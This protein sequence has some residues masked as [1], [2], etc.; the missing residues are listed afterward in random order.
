M[1]TT[2]IFQRHNDYGK[3]LSSM[4]KEELGAIDSISA[5]SSEEE[6]RKLLPGGWYCPL[7]VHNSDIEVLLW[8]RGRLFRLM[9]APENLL[10]FFY[11][12]WKGK[13]EKR[14]KWSV[15]RMLLKIQLAEAERRYEKALRKKTKSNKT[16]KKLEKI[17]GD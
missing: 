15:A 6:K 16:R 1:G 14:T 7:E 13:V 5:Y 10:D 2:T 9:D 12:K 17:N 11:N 3:R 4:E 8:Y